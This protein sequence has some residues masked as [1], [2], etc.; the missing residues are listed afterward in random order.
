MQQLQEQQRAA[1][2][3]LVFGNGSVRTIPLSGERWVL[4][5]AD[6]CSIV[7]RDPTVS[8]R[9]VLIE[10]SGESFR[11]KDLGGSNPILLEGKP[12]P[13]GSLEV[14]QTLLV[15]LTRLTLERRNQ[16][17]PVLPATESTIVLSREVI[18]DELLNA[19]NGQNTFV[20]AARKVLERIEWTF[21]D[22]GDLEDV[23]EPLIELALNLTGRRRGLIARF[24]SD[25]GIETLATLDAMGP[26]GEIRIP[27]QMLRDARRLG[28][29]NLITT[30]DRDRSVHRMLVP[31]GPGPDGLMVVEEPLP[32]A[33][34]GQELLRLGR[35][36]GRVIWHRLQETQ[37]RQRLRDEVQRL[38]FQGTVA[39]Q[40]LLASTRLHEIRQQLRERANDERIIALVGESGSE[41][42]E[43]AHYLHAEGTRAKA[44]FVSTSVGSLPP[45]RCVA[46][47][48]GDAG[49]PG[50]IERARGGTLFVDGFC[51][52]PPAIQEQVL[53]ALGHA[54][55]SLAPR[56]V[57]GCE[58][59]P[60]SDPGQWARPVLDAV[61]GR[62]FVIPPLRSDARDIL[63]LAE[64]FLSDL[65]PGPDGAPRLLSERAKRA[66][67]GHPWSGNIRELRHVLEQAAARAGGQPIAPRHLPEH[68]S[69]HTFQPPAS[70]IATLDQVE[71]AHIREVLQR[72][73]G[74]RAKAA[75]ALGI[76]AST[77]YEKL[78]RYAIDA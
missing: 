5:R 26:C 45:D 14:G 8:R 64:L 35:A 44:P 42:E 66:L 41:A 11:F 29:P 63:T 16:P 20:A 51:S 71:A 68:F 50:A 62:V 30:Q 9:H 65:G 6:D 58:S 34:N 43:L 1:Y 19:Q 77:L 74:N 36:L 57:I 31:L 18:D 47:L 37:E 49:T 22:L 54:A 40:A 15:G 46:E 3:L 28:R 12:Q 55:G 53:E 69:E 75:Q 17:A 7:I 60:G 48:L 23:A 70:D 25:E 24:R 21:A 4:G 76:A 56:L 59:M 33:P 73:G 2:R 78:K 67:T 27:E 13:E 72:V 10:R 52:L 39:H 38:R 32:D 61:A